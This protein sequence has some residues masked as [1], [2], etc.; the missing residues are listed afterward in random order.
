[1]AFATIA[2]YAQC[3]SAFVYVFS[4]V[5]AGGA[6]FVNWQ[7]RDADNVIVFQGQMNFD[8]ETNNQSSSVCLEQGCYTLRVIGNANADQNSFFG[9]MQNESSVAFAPTNALSYGTSI[10]NY[11]YCTDLLT[12][13]CNADFTAVNSPLEVSTF[14]FI[15]E[16]SFESF[17]DITYTWRFDDMGTSALLNPEFSF[18]ENGVFEVCLLI[19]TSQNGVQ[20]CQAESCQLLEVSGWFNENC[21]Q[22]I[23]HTG[24][25]GNYIFYVDEPNVS[26]VI[27]SIDGVVQS[28]SDQHLSYVFDISGPHEV[29]ADVTSADCEMSNVICKNINVNSCLY[30]MCTLELEVIELGNGSYEFTAFGL[31]EVYPMFWTFGDGASVA[32]TWVVIHHFDAPGVYVVCGSISDPMCSGAVQGCITITVED[33]S[34][35]APINFGIDSNLSEGGPLFLNYQLVIANSGEE[36]DAGFILYSNLD[37]SFDRMVCIDSACY[38]L[39]ICDPNNEINWSAVNVFGGVGLELLGWDEAC[40]G[41]RIYHF[42][43]FSK[44]A[45]NPLPFCAPSFNVVPQENGQYFF[46]NTS[47]FNGIA[48]YNWDFGDGVSSVEA[49]PSHFFSEPGIYS[50]C[51][52]LSTSFGCSN[53]EC[54]T[55]DILTV[56]DLKSMLRVFPNP[57]R[58]FLVVLWE[59]LWEDSQ[60]ELFSMDGR[61]VLS[62][63]MSG[64]QTVIPCGNIAQ[65]SYLL[66]LSNSTGI[67]RQL[68]QIH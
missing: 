17:Q 6:S 61:K 31:P 35:C 62:Q 30:P 33:V 38:D 18:F 64:T 10:F 37:Q 67:V 44:C 26:S 14:S 52:T 45:I 32:A 21:P 11:P 7:I 25:C 46:E 3:E 47:N 49:N 60:L 54:S 8:T 23:L 66:R 29:C 39:I 13:L 16:S 9:E 55:I 58:D 20:T 68:I 41:G 4:D 40:E 1:M 42:S 2:I 28:D 27:W 65:G 59:G 53:A 34:E 51:L 19:Q 57:A 12:T 24:Q 5:N 43:Y 48:A 36:V 63:G 22:E 56:E 15:N 50:V